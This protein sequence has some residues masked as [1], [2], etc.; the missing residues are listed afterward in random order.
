VWALP[1]FSQPATSFSPPPLSPLLQHTN[2]PSVI[3]QLVLTDTAGATTTV[4]SDASWLAFDGD[5]H[6][7]PG[8]ATQ[9]GSAGTAFL[10]YIDARGEPVGWRA[11]GFV[12][13]AG[14]GPAAAT[15]PSASDLANLH[16]RMQPSLSFSNL[17]VVSIT[18]VPAPPQPG[19]PVECGFVPENTQLL[20]G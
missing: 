20:L 3:F 11:P 4:V 15:P 19:V 6:R 12:P 14:W 1:P 16:P 10:E 2:S 5:A 18:P 7:K 9:G 13:G 8:P 17:T